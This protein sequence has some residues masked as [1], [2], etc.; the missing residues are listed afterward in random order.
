MKELFCD[1]ALHCRRGF[2]LVELFKPALV[3]HPQRHDRLSVSSVRAH[4]RVET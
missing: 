4:D 1:L 2:V 3:A